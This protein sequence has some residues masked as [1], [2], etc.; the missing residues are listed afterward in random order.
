MYNWYIRH[1]NGEKW[2]RNKHGGSNIRSGRKMNYFVQI[3]KIK[4]FNYEDK[5]LI[6]GLRTGCADRSDLYLEDLSDLYVQ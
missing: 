5:P 2:A 6:I 3:F 4:P 1:N